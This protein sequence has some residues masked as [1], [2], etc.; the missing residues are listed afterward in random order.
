MTSGGRGTS[1]FGGCSIMRETG[2]TG[3]PG[4][5]IEIMA[6]KQVTVQE[7]HDRQTL[8]HTY[9]DVRSVPEFAQGHPAGAVNVPLLHR[10]ERTG[11]MVP[12][13]DFVSTMQANFPT[14]AR[15]L[16]GCQVGG[17]SSQAA[18]L[19]ESAGYQDVSNVLG[20]YGGARDPMTGAVR[21]AGWT[22]A[23]L[24]VAVEDVP[25]Q[26]YET[27]RGRAGEKSK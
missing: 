4:R 8:G 7:A 12:N 27:L 5:S 20:G 11:Q 22:Q 19:L 24:P 9:V 6:V 23:G 18:Q 2:A 13:R 26:S 21:S 16:I 10:D 3:L 15:L 1:G 14:D 25:G 17:R